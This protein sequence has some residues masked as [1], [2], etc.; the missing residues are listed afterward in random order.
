M[1]SSRSSDHTIQFSPFGADDRSCGANENDD[2][3]RR[4]MFGKLR[5]LMTGDPAMPPTHAGD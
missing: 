2:L 4:Q 1:S 3:H 5:F